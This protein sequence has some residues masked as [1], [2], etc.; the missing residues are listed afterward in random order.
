MFWFFFWL[1]I[2]LVCFIVCVIIHQ[3][4]YIHIHCSTC[5]SV[6]GINQLCLCM[7]HF[8]TDKHIRY[9]VARTL[10]GQIFGVQTSS[11]TDVNVF[12]EFTVVLCSSID[13][14]LQDLMR[15]MI[16]LSAPLCTVVNTAEQQSIFIILGFKSWLIMFQNSCNSSRWQHFKCHRNSFM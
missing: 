13:C 14:Y 6:C 1:L 10:N 5:S 2:P 9:C 8:S 12:L 4:F 7:D 16:L 11:I 3:H 15:M